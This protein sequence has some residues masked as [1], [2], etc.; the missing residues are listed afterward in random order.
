MRAGA[1]AVALMLAGGAVAECGETIMGPEGHHK[2]AQLGKKTL[3]YLEASGAKVALLARA[4]SDAPRQRFVE[5]IGLWDY[6]HAGLAYRDHPAGRWTLVHL[7][8]VCAEESGV[9]AD[10]LMQFY[11]D[12]PFEYRAAVA[13][14]SPA[15]QD[16]LETVV[17]RRGGGEFRDGSIYSSISYPFS[18][19]RQ[20]SN[21]YALDTM[22]AALAHMEGRDVSDRRTAKEYF[23]TSPHRD[24]FV[25]EVLKTGMLES[26][27]AYLGL[28][29]DNATLSDHTPAELASRRFEFV[30]AGALVQFMENLG[31]LEATAEISL[32]DVSRASDTVEE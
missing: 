1:I 30:S 9:F 18:L 26:L 16:A 15:L 24:A 7:I 2:A 20:N 23:L 3:D 5:K 11:L 13:I 27:G 14:P 19:D 4:G 25:P 32:A 21:E 17:L 29:P 31:M 12:D 28:G 8:N 10:S 6:T 22:A